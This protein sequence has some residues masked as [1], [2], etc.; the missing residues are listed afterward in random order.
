MQI[1]NK[2]QMYELLRHGK[3]GN[4]MRVWGSLEEFKRSGYAGITSI[5]SKQVGCPVC[6]YDIRAEDIEHVVA[7][8]SVPA[9]SLT[10]CE[11]PPDSERTI[12]GELAL[13]PWGYTFFYT[14]VKKPMRLALAE[15]SA[16][17]SGLTALMLLERYVDPASLDDIKEL[18]RIYDGAV[19]E[20]SAFSICVGAIPN[21]QTVIWE[22]RHY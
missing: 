3:L 8:L 12:Q 2:T 7:G 6:L 10:F 15:Q 19:I 21:R 4:Y 9:N 1:T 20:F 22:V 13:G 11:A 14:T 17:A 18:L 16:Q 5:R